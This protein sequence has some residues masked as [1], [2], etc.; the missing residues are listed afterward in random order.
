MLP[1]WIRFFHELKYKH[2]ERLYTGTGTA[3][4]RPEIEPLLN[5]PFNQLSS[6]CVIPVQVKN[7]MKQVDVVYM[8]RELEVHTRAFSLRSNLVSTRHSKQ[9]AFHV[10]PSPVLQQHVTGH[11]H[12]WVTAI[13]FVILY[14]NFL[15]L[16][17]LL[18]QQWGKIDL[19][20]RRL[21]QRREMSSWSL[22]KPIALYSVYPFKILASRLNV[23]MD[24]GTRFSFRSIM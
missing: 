13:L 3:K 22:C 17:L 19:A 2:R 7:V 8:K 23:K 20:I 5:I 4:F 1:L 14:T 10:P 6:R 15:N 24:I 12:I 18:L 9:V 16:T 11:V 21:N